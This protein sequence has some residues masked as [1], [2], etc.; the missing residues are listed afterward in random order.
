[1]KGAPVR[2]RLFTYMWGYALFGRVR[3]FGLWARGLDFWARGLGLWARGFGLAARGLG[4]AARGFG[5][6]ARQ[7]YASAL[8]CVSAPFFDG[9]LFVRCAFGGAASL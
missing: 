7:T 1:M 5:L 3:G 6:A 4:L 8:F 2:V 9:S